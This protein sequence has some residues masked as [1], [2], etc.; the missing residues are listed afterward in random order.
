MEKM[1]DRLQKEEIHSKNLEERLQ[2]E[3]K[4]SKNLEERLQKE[5]NRSKSLEERLQKEENRS[6]DL[7]ERLQG[8]KVSKEL[9]EMLQ[10]TEKIGCQIISPPQ[11]ISHHPDNSHQM[12]YALTN[13]TAI[14]AKITKVRD[15]DYYYNFVNQAEVL[16]K[17]YNQYAVRIV[18][19][20][21]SDLQIGFCTEKG[22]GSTNNY[23][24]AESVYYYCVDNGYLYEGGACKDLSGCGSVNGE[25]V[26]C[27][28]DLLEGR[29][30]WW[31]GGN[32]L[33][34]CSMPVAMKGKPLYFSIILAYDGDS[35]E[36]SSF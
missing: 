26:E 2:R 12:Y 24:N 32:V 21:K 33:A 22:L 16:P 31:K 35:V 3:E 13:S 15:G 11:V 29:V 9:E 30:R 8:E 6:K 4:N 1:E 7:E 19:A 27:M 25:L 23:N 36:V 5:E 34:E 28:V 17:Q 10:R 14:S 20:R 18:K